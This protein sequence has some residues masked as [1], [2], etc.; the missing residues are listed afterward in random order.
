MYNAFIAVTL[1]FGMSLSHNQWTVQECCKAFHA[2]ADHY[3]F[4]TRILMVELMRSPFQKHGYLM[5]QTHEEGCITCKIHLT[6]LVQFVCLRMLPV[7]NHKPR[8]DR[9]IV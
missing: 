1:L 6:D 3:Q 8:T 2:N 4:T 5:D 7:V 9:N